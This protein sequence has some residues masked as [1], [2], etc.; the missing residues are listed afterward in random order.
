MRYDGWMI[1]FRY[2]KLAMLRLVMAAILL[3]I[4]SIAIAFHLVPKATYG[5][6]T[7]LAGFAGVL[8]FGSMIPVFSARLFQNGPTVEIGEQG[9]RD[10]R[11]SPDVVA[12]ETIDG[13]Q[14]IK[15]REQYS[16]RLQ[17]RAPSKLN[18]TWLN[19]VVTSG[20]AHVSINMAGL[21]GSF[22]DLVRAIDQYRKV[23]T[24]T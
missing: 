20:A 4:L 9:I 7:E 17:L 2:S 18:R 11:V 24:A 10:R 15:V 12:W 21:N 6:F 8:L 3:T 13:M 5:N 14:V 1:V 22:D 16:L 19:R 23:H